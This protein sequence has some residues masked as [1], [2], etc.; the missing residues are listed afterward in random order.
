MIYMFYIQYSNLT[1]VATV[2][3][4]SVKRRTEYTVCT[5]ADDGVVCI[6]VA[7]LQNVTKI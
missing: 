3:S 1:T 7:V 2:H 4:V 6:I 5:F